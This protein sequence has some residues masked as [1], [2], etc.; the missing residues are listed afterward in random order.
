M[1]KYV[2]EQCWNYNE[3]L[4]CSVGTPIEKGFSLSGGIYLANEQKNYQDSG[5]TSCQIH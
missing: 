2:S 4:L 3:I 5:I 1:Y